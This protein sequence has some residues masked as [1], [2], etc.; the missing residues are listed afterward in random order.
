M[1]GKIITI[2]G[3]YNQT[4]KMNITQLTDVKVIDKIV[5]NTGMT[6]YN[7]TGYIG[8]A[9]DKSVCNFSYDKIIK[10]PD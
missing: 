2:N 8:I 1:I 4:A 10:I 6:G 7:E 9:N 3:G 5:K